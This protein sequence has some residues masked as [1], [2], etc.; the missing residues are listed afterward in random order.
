MAT[1]PI[2]LNGSAI[3]PNVTRT[4][5]ISDAD[6]QMLLNWAAFAFN[7]YIQATFNPTGLTT[8][9]PTN[10]QILL[11]WLEN[12]IVIPTKRGIQ[13]FQTTVTTPAPITMA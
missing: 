10:Q 8:F 2:S 12:Q 13:Q 6:L 7:G 3:I 4:L 1:I 5:T 9:V 11:A